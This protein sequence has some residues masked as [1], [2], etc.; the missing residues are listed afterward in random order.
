[1]TE[2]LSMHAWETRS[3]MPQVKTVH[4]TQTNISKH[5]AKINKYLKR[6]RG[7]GREMLEGGSAAQRP[8]GL[9][10]GGSGDSGQQ[11]PPVLGPR[12]DSLSLVFCH[13]TLMLLF[14]LCCV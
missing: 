11:F 5:Q 2:Q 7:Y 8:P 14:S 3:H 9:T 4:A 12:L 1:M 10:A 6:R 13:P